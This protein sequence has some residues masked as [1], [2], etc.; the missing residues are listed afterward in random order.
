MTCFCW[1]VDVMINL[2]LAMLTSIGLTLVRGI[3]GSSNLAI[4]CFFLLSESSTSDCTIKVRI[5]L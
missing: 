3:A 5:C 2:N 4:P 1:C